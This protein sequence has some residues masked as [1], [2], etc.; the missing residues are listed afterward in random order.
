MLVGS[1]LL[2]DQ[3]IL[4]DQHSSFS[5]YY[6]GLL[7]DETGSMRIVDVLRNK[8][9]FRKSGQKVVSLDVMLVPVWLKFDVQNNS[10]R[11]KWFLEFISPPLLHEVEVYVVG[12]GGQYRSV[13]LLGDQQ[14]PDRLVKVKNLVVPIGLLPGE[15]AS[16][17]VRVTSRNFM[18]IPL[19]I[20]TMQ[21]LYESNHKVDVSNGVIFG[22]L[23]AFMIYNLFVFF[24]LREI[25]YLFY[26]GY[27]FFWGLN[28]VNYNG[29]LPDFIPH[30]SGFNDS[31]IFIACSALCSVGFT[32]AFLQTHIYAPIISRTKWVM[33]ALTLVP[34]ILVMVGKP[35]YA[36]IYIQLLV[37]P[38]FMYWFVAG[39]MSFRN[40]YKPA[41]YYIVGFGCYMVGS[42]I[43]N[44]KDH[45]L[46]PENTFTAT[47][48]H[49]G[50][51]FEAVILSYALANKLSF[52]KREKEKIQQKALEQTRAFSQQVLESQETER[53]RIAAELHDSVGQRLILLKNKILLLGKKNDV[54]KEELRAVSGDVAQ[55][56]QEIR[57]IAYYLRP[58]QIDLFGISQALEAVVNETSK[59]TGIAVTMQ[60]DKVDGL[61]SKENEINVYRIVQELLN[62]MV[63]YAEA[64]DCSFL[65]RYTPGVV[66]VLFEDN[67][68]GFDPTKVKKGL[69]LTGIQER[70]NI[71]GGS[72]VIS[73]GT[74]SGVVTK[75]TLPV[76]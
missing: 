15:P 67:G 62:N 8:E 36:F 27:V 55:A 38:V 65:V 61:F 73:N 13:K 51:A 63:K 48:M 40:G 60:V 2:A 74:R 59:A 49:W 4:E 18:R 20:A 53:K 10:T 54:Q 42:A 47:S 37:Y 26:V 7:K 46:L 50:A 9:A 25:S 12:K 32:N 68:K 3:V 23:I 71:L 52:Y 57:G 64:T 58:Y 30:A 29:Y 11:S 22:M 66:T 6:P 56:I 43:Y 34:M 1:R 76:N 17:Y 69:G 75:I 14:F 5:I 44:L 24:S 41:L 35:V 16:F 19:R 72:C 33:V 28:L 45:N 70:V 21:E 31:S 39:F